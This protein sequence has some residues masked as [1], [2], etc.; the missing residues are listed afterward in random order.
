MQRALE[1]V[2][3][4]RKVA[5]VERVLAQQAE[6]RDKEEGSREKVVPMA[7]ERRSFLHSPVG[8]SAP[9]LRCCQYGAFHPFFFL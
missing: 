5:L 9:V 1:T 7:E 8:E 6:T 4:I 3:V 2:R